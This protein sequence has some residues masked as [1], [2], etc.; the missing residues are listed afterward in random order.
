MNGFRDPMMIRVVAAIEA[1]GLT[2]APGPVPEETV[3][4]GIRIEPGRLV[5]DEPRTPYPGDVLH[6]AGH[7][8]VLPPADRVRADGRLPPDGGQEMAALAWSYA[9]AVRFDLPLEVVFHDAFK[10]DGPW[11]RRT[12]TGGT[13]LGVPLLQ[14]W[15]MTR[16]ARAPAG[17]EHLPQFPEMAR[18]LRE[19]A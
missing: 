19:A 1:V 13:E 9:M 10:A 11:L 8:A 16:Q 5:V 12:F 7:L 6:E 18:W 2:V 15:E 4:P 14:L 3:L 17:F